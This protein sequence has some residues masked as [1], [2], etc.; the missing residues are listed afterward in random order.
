MKKIILIC[1]K[2]GHGKTTFANYLQEQLELKGN[3]VMRV[4]NAD[5]LKFICQ[6]YFNWNTQKDEAGRQLLQ[7]VG[8][9]IVRAKNEDFWARNTV[10][11]IE[12]FK[13]MFDYFIVDDVRFPNEI[14]MFD[15]SEII[16]IKIERFTAGGVYVN[17]LMT[18]EQLSHP[19]EVSLD[20][21]RC[22][23]YIP[24][25]NGLD[26]LRNMA[27]TLLQTIDNK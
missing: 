5:Y 24:N 26:S 10:Q 19:S 6:K 22:N 23:Y 7:R 13:D 4:A 12:V 20:R 18:S 1:G 14:D 21:R 2:A 16:T 9:D 3:T 27:I 15:K 25:I 11:L 8:T 17:P